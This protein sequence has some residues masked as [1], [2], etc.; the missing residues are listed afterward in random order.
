MQQLSFVLAFCEFK[1]KKPSHK[2]SDYFV[3]GTSKYYQ[4]M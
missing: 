4:Q 3:Y 1:K 2:T